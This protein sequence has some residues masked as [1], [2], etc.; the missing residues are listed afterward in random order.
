MNKRRCGVSAPAL[1]QK[2]APEYAEDILG[3]IAFRVTS[4]MVKVASS[5]S[6]C[7]AQWIERPP[8]EVAGS[9]PAADRSRV[10]N[11]AISFYHP[12]LTGATA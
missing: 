1:R 2:Q 8:G 4:Q 3:L 12:K 11:P 6:K 10:G 9:S 5:L 7:V